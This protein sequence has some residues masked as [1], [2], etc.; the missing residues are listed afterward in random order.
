PDGSSQEVNHEA[1]EYIGLLD[2]RQVATLLED[3]QRR[4]AQQP[5]ILLAAVE[6]HD[7]ILASPD[8]ERRIRHPREKP[9][10]PRIVHIGLP[11]EPRGHFLVAHGGLQGRY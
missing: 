6:G 5:P 9:G 3:G 1:R 7:A 11:G 8:D 4:I 2:W 10:E